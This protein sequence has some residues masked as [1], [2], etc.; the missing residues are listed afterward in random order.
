MVR[1]TRM[2]TAYLQQLRRFSRDARLYL[3]SIAVVGLA[4]LGLYA[5][6]FNLYLL[7]LG[8]GPEFIGLVNGVG[9]LVNALFSLPAGTLGS[10]WGIRR[11][12]IAGMGLQA[13]MGLPTP[14]THLLPVSW[15]AGWLLATNA[16]AWVG[17][18]LYMVN[19]TPFLM[20]VTTPR[21]RD[22][23]FSM[24][25]ALFPLAGFLG[26]LVSGLLPGLL[27]AKLGASLDGP[28]PYGY[29]LLVAPILY[30]LS[31]VALLGTRGYGTLQRQEAA[32]ATGS[33]PHVLITLIAL[34]VL[35]Q[36]AG[37]WGARVFFN[38]YLDAGLS[39]PTSL[40]GT[41]F[42]VAQLLSVPA[43]LAMPLLVGRLGR[44]RTITLAA[45]SVAGSLLP[46]ALI[47]H[48]VAGGLGFMGMIAAASIS[49]SAF[50]VY[51]QDI[52]PARWRAITSGAVST[53]MGLSSSAMAFGGGYIIGTAGY[54]SL[55][56]LGA[57][58]TA[59]GALLFWICFRVPGGGIAGVRARQS[60]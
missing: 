42:A 33:S 7:R 32:P 43:A 6:L 24:M 60:E 58:L 41:L 36:L 31:L 14:F 48:W 34:I 37:E 27:A 13:V 45:L 4:W 18:A 26:S 50:M 9:F 30:G 52:M 55:F 51:H 56:L 23:V 15:R 3:A 2:V 46:M 25:T 59:A 1:G 16:L 19:G 35:L 20:A 5:V 8:Y 29:T 11:L 21:E 10:R 12:M 40:V 53:A 28:A 38:V 47:P 17:G 44:E 22:H 39:T 54:R 57:T 49:A